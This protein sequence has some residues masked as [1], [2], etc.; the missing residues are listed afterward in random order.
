M[1]KTP[2]AQNNFE[3]GIFNGT[4]FIG[5][6]DMTDDYHFS[7]DYS[8]RP[9]KRTLCIRF[10]GMDYRFHGMQSVVICDAINA[11]LDYF[12]GGANG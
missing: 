8:T 10:K 5:I 9:P 11:C 1:D 7:A 2:F 4:D 3:L 6:N 12:E